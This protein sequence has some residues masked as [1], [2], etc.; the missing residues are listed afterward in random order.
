LR[1]ILH[2]AVWNPEQVDQDP[3]NI[4]NLDKHLKRN[5][6]KDKQIKPLEECHTNS[7]LR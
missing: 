2:E 5:N 4:V 1:R 3:V 6:E 7:N